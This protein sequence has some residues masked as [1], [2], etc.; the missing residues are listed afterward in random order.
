MIIISYFIFVILC[1][2]ALE[3]GNKAR[4]DMIS[5][6]SLSVMGDKTHREF[7]RIKNLL[8][9]KKKAELNIPKKTSAVRRKGRR[10]REEL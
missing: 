10:V 8:K 4:A 5:R 6:F 7:D 3:K 1:I 2:Q 9:A